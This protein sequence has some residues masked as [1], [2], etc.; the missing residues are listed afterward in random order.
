MNNNNI[1]NNECKTNLSNLSTK[2]SN[3]IQLTYKNNI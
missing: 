3:E 1:I 2:R